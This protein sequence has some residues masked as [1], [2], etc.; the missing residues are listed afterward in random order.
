M[1]LDP[2]EIWFVTGSQ[3]LY[4]D[5]VLRQVASNSQAIAQALNGSGALPVELVF[6]PAAD[7]LQ[8]RFDTLTRA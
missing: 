2:C 4:G 1:K 6:K 3:H 5:E 8:A 7:T